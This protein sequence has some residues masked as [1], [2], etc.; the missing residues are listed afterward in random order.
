MSTQKTSTELLDMAARPIVKPRISKSVRTGLQTLATYCVILFF[1]VLT[2]IP[3][4]W[5][6]STSLKTREQLYV[7]PPQ[8]IPSPIDFESYRI[9]FPV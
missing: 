9:L 6:L 5:M 7:F 3:F 1:A 2:L 8:W 4:L